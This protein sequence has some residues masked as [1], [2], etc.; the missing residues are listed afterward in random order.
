MTQGSEKQG[1]EEWWDLYDKDGQYIGRHLRGE[2][3]PPDA[4]HSIVAIITMNSKNEVLLTQRD[5]NKSYPG[6]WETTAGSV[7][8][9]ESL[10]AG[11]KRE[12]FEETGIRCE[13][14]ELIYL[15]PLQTTK[16]NGIMFTYFL[17]KDVDINDIV[18]Q[19][20]EAIDAVWTPLDWS[21]ITD[22][23]IADS[24]WIRLIYY[25][26]DLLALLT[27]KKQD[28]PWLVWAKKLQAIA[29]T[30]ME[31]SKDPY[32]RDRFEQISDIASEMVSYKTGINHRKVLGLFAYEKGYQ[33]PKMETRASVFYEDR[34]LLVQERKTQL[35]SM[36]GGWCDIG[37]G[38]AEN[39]AKECLEEAS[40]E[41]EVGK[42]VAIENRS[43]HDYTEYPYEIYKAYFI[44][45]PKKKPLLEEGTNRIKNFEANTETTDARF[46]SLDYLPDL[47]TDRIT[48]RSIRMCFNAYKDPD[49]EAKID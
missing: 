40:L 9:G 41:V 46:F 35:W 44:C 14:E 42:L 33:T 48:E 13:E 30:G 34:I 24:V 43:D 12:L 49:W 28:S 1:K 16:G 26:Q 23:R 10:R 2:E 8:E 7:L 22:E 5:Y 20:G 3:L 39:T 21:L 18:L 19:E 25:W 27:D 17:H 4:Y 36:P 15:G 38:L 47:A 6:K 32:D 45:E 31:Y 37:Y 29:Q 11:A